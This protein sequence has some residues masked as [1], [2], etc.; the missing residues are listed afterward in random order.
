LQAS[1]DIGSPI[2][3]KEDSHDAP[4]MGRDATR[5]WTVMALMCFIL[6]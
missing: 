1:F 3:D 5:S 6:G 2:V 4:P